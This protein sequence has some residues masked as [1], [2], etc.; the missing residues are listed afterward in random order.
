MFEHRLLIRWRLRF[1]RRLLWWLLRPLP[2]LGMWRR[3]DYREPT[4][5]ETRSSQA[6]HLQATQAYESNCQATRQHRSACSKTSVTPKK[7]TL[8]CNDWVSSSE[9]IKSNDFNC[10]IQRYVHPLVEQPINDVEALLREEQALKQELATDTFETEQR[11]K[12]RTEILL[13]N[14]NS[15]KWTENGE[16]HNL[17]MLR[18]RK[19]GIAI[20]N[21]EQ[22]LNAL[23]KTKRYTAKETRQ[24]GQRIHSS[25]EH[26]H[27]GP[28]PAL[29]Y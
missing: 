6:T 13:D 16:S 7:I 11:L 3:H 26:S 22:P 14:I 8:R 27:S 24:G 23:F 18:P 20:R 10:S 28:L 17:M 25:R 1:I 9:E 19:C 4:T 2:L 21:C 15:A 29:Q 12:E 5:R